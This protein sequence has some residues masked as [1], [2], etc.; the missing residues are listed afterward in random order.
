MLGGSV[1]QSILGPQYGFGKYNIA[2]SLICGSKVTSTAG[3]SEFLCVRRVRSHPPLD[4]E[5]YLT[6]DRPGKAMMLSDPCSLVR[7]KDLFFR[8]DLPFHRRARAG[9][10][11]FAACGGTGA[12]RSPRFGGEHGEDPQFDRAEHDATLAARQRLTLPGREQ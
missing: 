4:K 7:S 3:V 10:V 11:K 12:T 1:Y 9:P 5:L 6:N 2:H 8:P